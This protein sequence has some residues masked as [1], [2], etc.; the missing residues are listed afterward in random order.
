T[1]TGLQYVI[2]TEDLDN[3]IDPFMTLYDS[4]GNAGVQHDN[5][6]DI[7]L[8]ARIGFI[9]GGTGYTYIK[10]ENKSNNTPDGSEYCV[11]LKETLV[12][13]TPT[14]TLTPTPTE[15]PENT[16]TITLTPSIT[17]EGDDCEPNET[18][19]DACFMA[20]GE[21]VN[22]D[23]KPP[24]GQSDDKDFYKIFVRRGIEY[25]CTTF[26]LSSYADTMMEIRQADG[27]V[28]LGDNNDRVPLNPTEGSEVVFKPGADGDVYVIITAFTRPEKDIEERYTYDL[29]CEGASPTATP[30]PTETPEPTATPDFADIG[31]V[32][33]PNE[34]PGDAC[35]ITTG[36]TVGNNFAPPPGYRTDTDYFRMFVRK[37][38]LYTCTTFN[39]SNFTDTRL[40]I[41]QEQGFTWLG[42]NDNAEEFNPSSGSEVSFQSKIDGNVY[43]IVRPFTQPEPE[44]ET[45]Y[46][47]DLRCSSEAPTITPT[48]S[49]TPLPTSTPRPVNT[50]RP[51]VQPPTSG[52]N[53]GNNP[54]TALPAPTIPL[55][56]TPTALPT[57]TPTPNVGFVPLPTQAPQETPQPSN[58]SLEVLVYYDA[59][60]NFSAETTEGIV[61][62]AVS[63]YDNVT[64]DLLAFG[65]TNSNGIVAF[66]GLQPQG[67]LRVNIEFLAVSQIVPANSGQ[68]PI[69][70]SPQ[71][72]PN[73]IP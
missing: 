30:E 54:A 27:Y 69:R 18:A 44:F 28:W 52:G 53:S 32:C 38:V 43:I 24:Y 5:I 2:Q 26:N 49:E 55:L 65:Y 40:E 19:N 47:Y 51:V 63:I 50:P 42:D 36:Q 4:N 37:H 9:A 33:E 13:P 7:D 21:T 16:P 10:L 71:Q 12:T 57:M 56:P 25:T 70:V 14:P 22:G 66:N 8:N 73:L 41:R 15:T 34:T 20:V 35:F 58:V 60:E 46:T 29:K 6:S 72:M 68:I 11:I 61:D 67:A 48:P 59:N 45:S 17:P 62:I 1:Q 23:F 64:G 39:L 31:D 3:G